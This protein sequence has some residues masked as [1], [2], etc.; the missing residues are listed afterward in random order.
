MIRLISGNIL[1]AVYLVYIIFYL[2]QG[3]KIMKRQS[4]VN[5]GLVLIFVL[6][7]SWINAQIPQLINYQGYL[8]DGDGN[9]VTGTRSIEYRMYETATGGTAIWSETQSVTVLDGVFSVLLGSVN[10]LS[11]TLFNGSDRFLALKVGSDSEM[12]PRIRLVSV[13]YAFRA[14]QADSLGGNAA[15]D[16]VEAGSIPDIISSIDGVS[17]NGGNV[18]LVEGSN[19]TITPNDAANTITIA[20]AGGGGGDITAVTAGT[21]LT[22]GGNSGDVTLSVAKPLELSSNTI[23]PLIKASYSLS[24]S[25]GFISSLGGSPSSTVGGAVYGKEYSI[26]GDFEGALGYNGGVYGEYSGIGGE[27]YG[28]LGCS[29]GAYGEDE[30]SGNYGYLG[31]NDYGVYGQSGG[32]SGILGHIGGSNYGS[33]GEYGNKSY[34]YLGG[35][36]YGV[37][38]KHKNSGNYGYIGGANYSLIGYNLD[39]G[40]WAGIGSNSYAGYFKGNVNITGSLSKGGGSFKIDHPLD[41]ANKYLQHSFVESPDMMNVYNGNVRLDGNGEAVVTLPD[42][43]ESLNRDFRYQLTAIGAPGPD[44][45]IAKEIVGNQFTIAGGEPDMKV[46][47]QVTGIRQDAWAENNRIQVEVE[48]EGE[49]RGTY[50]YPEL[51]GMPVSSRVDYKEIQIDRKIQQQMEE[52]YKKVREEQLRIQE[53]YKKLQ[54]GK[55]NRPHQR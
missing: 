9:P 18:D 19:I 30:S 12:T 44:L 31:G 43:F 1:N 35:Y 24:V 46:S 10:P 20:A 14:N 42:Y 29:Y 32:G 38:G 8:A 33:Y 21:G 28:I 37:Y 55:H 36:Y 34:G 49:E 39:S 51:Y 23:S 11:Y 50:L 27:T 48:K 40:N 52:E 15:D 13:G 47:W 4:A 2:K 16:F 6:S 7:V 41:P 22:G 5:T 54:V 45:Y 3:G 25:H 26:G 53:E 17:N